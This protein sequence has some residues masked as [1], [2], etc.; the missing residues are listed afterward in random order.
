MGDGELVI[1]VRILEGKNGDQEIV[2]EY[3]VVH[4]IGDAAGPRHVVAALDDIS[5]LLRGRLDDIFEDVFGM[6][7]HV[8]PRHS[9]RQDDET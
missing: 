8:G 6:C 7:P 5:L 3:R 4:L 9:D 1:D 2:L